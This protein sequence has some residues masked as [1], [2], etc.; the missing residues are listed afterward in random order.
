MCLWYEVAGLDAQLLWVCEVGGSQWVS[1]TWG[2]G[3][4]IALNLVCWVLFQ[5][6]SNR[7]QCRVEIVLSGNDYITKVTLVTC[8]GEVKSTC[9]TWDR[10]EWTRAQPG[11]ES[12]QNCAVLYTWSSG[13]KCEE[14][15]KWA[16]RVREERVGKNKDYRISV[17][18]PEV[19]NT[20]SFK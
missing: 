12:E 20:T 5:W 19:T 1:S 4:R 3:G 17:F 11:S 9:F 16:Q 8:R 6:L 13:N 15:C 14:G 18:A 7:I 2:G 10:K